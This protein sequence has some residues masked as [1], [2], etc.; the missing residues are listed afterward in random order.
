MKCVVCGKEINSNQKFCKYCGTPVD[1]TVKG[2]T[3]EGQIQEEFQNMVQCPSCGRLI[4]RGNVYCTECGAPLSSKLYQNENDENKAI[5][6]K[7]GKTAKIIVI[8]SSVIIV[9]LLATIVLYFTKDKLKFGENDQSTLG[10][11]EQSTEEP[12]KIIVDTEEPTATGKA[13]QKEDQSTETVEETSEMPDQKTAV[14][15]A[16]QPQ[17]E[18]PEEEELQTEVPETIQPTLSPVIISYAQ[19]LEDVDKEYGTSMIYLLYDLDGDGIKELFVTK[20]NTDSECQWYVYTKVNGQVVLSGDFPGA[21]SSLC[22][23]NDGIFYAINGASEKKSVYTVKM[24]N[25]QLK[26][27]CIVNDGV[28]VGSGYKEPTG[29]F[30]TGLH[31]NDHSLLK[32]M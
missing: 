14:S 11:A 16:K 19:I 12:Q 28:P 18:A 27:D 31:I 25:K 7:R 1:Q 32:G 15:E 26:W 20:G 24:Q 9:A 2:N 8:I 29:E 3:E 30:L 21:Y 5:K 13:D 23:G 22:K 10:K 6:N 17:T 4:K